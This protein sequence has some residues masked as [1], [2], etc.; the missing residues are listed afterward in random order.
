MKHDARK[1]AVWAASAA[2]RN[3][4]CPGSLTLELELPPTLRR[5]SEA[6]AT[7]TA[8]HQIAERLLRGGGDA[9]ELVGTTEPADGMSIHIDEELAHGI[10]AYL[11][12]CR[13]LA[14][15]AAKNWIEE[16]FTLD[17]LNIPFESGGTADFV[18]WLRG[19][20]QLVVVD[21]KGGKGVLVEVENNNQL[22]HYALGA[23]LAHPDI[24]ALVQT[25]R[26]VIVQ[27]R[28]PHKDG[29]VRSEVFETA[30]LLDWVADLRSAMQ[31]ADDA[32]TDYHDAR[33]N[34]VKMEAWRDLYLRPGSCCQ[35]CPSEGVCPALRHDALS[36]AEDWFEDAAPNLPIGN[37]PEEIA[38][39]L[40][41]LD[42]I[43][44]WANARR[45]L[46]QQMAEAG[47]E[48][49]GF[50]L[51]DKRG[52]R[53][54][55]N[56]DEEA[57]ALEISMATGIDEDHL[58]RRTLM[59]PAQ[60]DKLLASGAR[61]KTEPLWQMEVSGKNLVQRGKSNR[62]EVKSLVSQFMEKTDD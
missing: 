12:F 17:W 52:T 54:W 43:Q 33:L 53:R 18:A 6:S 20:Q 4:A 50:M 26:I 3:M 45:Q 7:G 46:A 29:L 24:A 59:S 37:S 62:P 27:P 51:V 41:K 40:V 10:D 30:D 14:R 47:I 21:L 42:L 55:I 38:A 44:N 58:F 2:H 35:F 31:E 28:A 5:V 61:K 16:K 23:L 22:R 36:M 19:E 49:P 9:V 1:H 32:L 11:A 15:I 60:V 8:M 25:I 13:D 39:D 57:A 48:I 34:A 56:K